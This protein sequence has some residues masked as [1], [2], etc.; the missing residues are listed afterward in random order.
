MSQKQQ[1]CPVCGTTPAI[2]D[3]TGM[4]GCQ[5]C[6]QL[7]EREIR[8]CLNRII[9][10]EEGEPDG[11]AVS[12]ENHMEIIFRL[13]KAVEEEDYEKAAFLRDRLHALKEQGE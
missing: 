12:D 10:M 9:T 5:D 8:S 11:F 1:Q 3:A 6:Y 13:Q 2:L 7:F 4:V